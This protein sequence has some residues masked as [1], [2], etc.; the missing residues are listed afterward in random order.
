MSTKISIYKSKRRDLRALPGGA[1]LHPPRQVLN[2][3]TKKAAPHPLSTEARLAESRNE[4][5]AGEF[6]HC[7][8]CRTTTRKPSVEEG[9]RGKA[10]RNAQAELDETWNKTTARHE[11]GECIRVPKVRR[12]RRI[13]YSDVPRC[14]E[15]HPEHAGVTCTARAVDDS[16][17]PKK[18]RGKHRAKLARGAV[19][20][21]AEPVDVEDGAR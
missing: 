8:R 19:L 9:L 6:F 2:L 16:G 7:W 10:K 13:R 15:Q 4:A 11:T 18:H 20:R 17:K 3:L 14:G 5:H 12:R 1:G 21:W